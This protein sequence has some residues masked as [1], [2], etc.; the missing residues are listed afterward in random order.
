VWQTNDLTKRL[1]IR[2]PLLQ[3]PMAIV[4]T[5]ALAAAVAESGGL[6]ALGCAV[7]SGDQV[8]EQVAAFRQMT[9][10][11]FPIHLNFFVH[12][13]PK[14]NPGKEQ[15]VSRNVPDG[16]PLWAGQAAP[17]VREGMAADIVNRLVRETEEALRRV[18]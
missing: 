7:L 2:Y 9:S 5:P 8:R 18:S 6:G 15:S 12:K 3:A 16:L 4:T 13:R 14:R 17:L 1:G 11:R 10:R